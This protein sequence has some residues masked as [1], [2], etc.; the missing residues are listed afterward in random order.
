MSFGIKI[1]TARLLGKKKFVVEPDLVDVIT[2]DTFERACRSLGIDPTLVRT[3]PKKALDAVTKIDIGTQGQ[4][5]LTIVLKNPLQFNLKKDFT[6]AAAERFV[7][8][9]AAFFLTLSLAD[10]SDPPQGSKNFTSLQDS[11]V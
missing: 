1:W 8:Q 10:T 4:E 3:E 9:V 2:L 5:F 6:P 7:A 11:L